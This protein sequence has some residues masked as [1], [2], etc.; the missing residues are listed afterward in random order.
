MNPINRIAYYIKGL[1]PADNPIYK[2]LFLLYWRI[3]AHKRLKRKKS[4]TFGINLVRHCNLNCQSC[5]TFSPIADEC[6][7]DLQTVEK[8][9]KQFAKLE[10]GGGGEKVGEIGLSGGE[11]LLYPHIVDMILLVRKYFK[12]VLICFMTN[13]ILLPKQDELFWQTCGTNNVEITIT[14]YPIKIDTNTIQALAKKY[15]VKVDIFVGYEKQPKTT[16][17]MPLDI[18]GKQNIKWN[19]LRCYRANT[20]ISLIDGKLSTCFT[21]LYIKDINKYFG[22]NFVVTEE[23]YIDIYKVK[24]IGEILDFLCKPIPFC[25]YCAIKDYKLGIPWGISKKESKEWLLNS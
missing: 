25:R 16:H 23:D 7:A 18:Q 2:H 5:D 6:F 4:L 10:M 19:F 8:D 11:P 14:P 13:G 9:L 24:N 1:I 21:P 22:Q 20:C 17:I 12:D 3:T 15:N